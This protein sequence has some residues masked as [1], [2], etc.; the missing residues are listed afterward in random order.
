MKYSL[1]AL[2]LLLA[3]LSSC[4]I[5]KS[6]TIENNTKEAVRLTIVS[7]DTQFFESDTTSFKLTATGLTKRTDI[8][9]HLGNWS[10]SDLAQFKASIQSVVIAQASGA[11]RLN[12]AEQIFSSLS[13]KR[14]GLLN[15]RIKVRI[16]PLL[17]S[18]FTVTK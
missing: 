7:N 4:D 18:N 3:T 5:M 17:P 11:V 1:A 16:R 13:V 12:D 2:L 15:H 14:K 10:K 8:V 9:Y 6:L